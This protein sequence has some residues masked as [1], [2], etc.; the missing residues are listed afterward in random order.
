MAHKQI[1][2]VC[3]DWITEC[4]RYK[5]KVDEERYHPRLLNLTPPPT[6]PK[7]PTPEPELPPQQ[8]TPKLEPKLEPGTLHMTIPLHHMSAA[9]QQHHHY[10]YQP[11]YA[12]PYAVQAGIFVLLPC[13]GMLSFGG[14]RL[15]MHLLHNRC[16][17]TFSFIYF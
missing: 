17:I 10:G 12:P 8:L 5:S 15:D 7:P 13:N 1:R 9:Q 2:I 16:N 6:P 3:P 14:N 11:H 4:V